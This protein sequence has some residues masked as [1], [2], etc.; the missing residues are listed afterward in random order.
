[1]HEPM[2]W[3]LA[4]FTVLVTAGIVL[5]RRRKGRRKVVPAE[6]PERPYHI[7]SIY[8]LK[9]NYSS[10]HF[11]Y[12]I[13]ECRKV[14][15]RV[16]AEDNRSD[17]QRA[18]VRVLRHLDRQLSRA[19]KWVEEEADLLAIVLRN[20][21]ELRFWTEY[22]STGPEETERFLNEVNI[23]IQ[24]LHAKMDKAFPGALEQLPPMPKG[25]RIDLTRVDD[26]EEY[27][28]KLCSKLIHATALTINHPEATTENPNNREYIA[29]EV[30]FYA[31]WI[32]SRFHDLNWTD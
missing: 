23:D 1:M 7:Q 21:I 30:L 28:F 6:P 24:D 19:L 2:I 12:A 11:C 10:E 14:I 17:Q 4:A 26:N 13:G 20:L 5:Y 25:R 3:M 15:A 8:D 16:S 31:W 22:I 9:E 32:V 18:R 29:V 27:N